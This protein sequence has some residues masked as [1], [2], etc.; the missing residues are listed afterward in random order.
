MANGLPRTTK[1]ARLDVDDHL[2]QLDN[3]LDAHDAKFIEVVNG[4]NARFDGVEASLRKVMWTGVTLLVTVI[5]ALATV[6]VFI[7]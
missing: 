4:V 2:F 3:D 7:R 1:Y 6:I 5:G